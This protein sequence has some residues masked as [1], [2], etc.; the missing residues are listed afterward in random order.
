MKTSHPF[1]PFPLLAIGIGISLAIAA[2][3]LRAADAQTRTLDWNRA[4]PDHAL[5]QPMQPAFGGLSGEHPLEKKVTVPAA[6]APAGKG[7]FS[8]DDRAIIIVGGKTTTAGQVKRA[9]QAEIAAKAGAPKTVRGG[10][11]KL[12]LTALLGAAGRADGS[13]GR[14]ADR[15]GNQGGGQPRL[16][17]LPRQGPAEDL[18]ITGQAEGRRNRLALGAMLRRPAGEGRAHRPVP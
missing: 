13:P 10:A 2:P 7:L 15:L 8:L 12:D 5:Q 16:A 11:R 6:A 18:G 3:T 9:L 1:P 4:A 17:P 14:D